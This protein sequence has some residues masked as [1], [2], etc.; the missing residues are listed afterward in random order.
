[1]T[2]SSTSSDLPQLARHVLG[3]AHQRGARAPAPRAA[4]HEHLREVGA[5]RLVLGLVE[6]QLHRADDAALVLGDQQRAFAAGHVIGDARA[7]TPRALASG[8]G[9]MKLT[10]APPSTQSISTS[11]SACDLGVADLPKAP[12]GAASFGSVLAMSSPA[13]GSATITTA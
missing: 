4:V 12:D 7:R 5:V 11:A 3:G 10:E 6:H 13:G 9:C 8:R 2:V 1:M